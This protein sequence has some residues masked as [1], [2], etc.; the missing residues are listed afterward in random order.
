[1]VKKQFLSDN[2]DCLHLLSLMFYMHNTLPYYLTRCVDLLPAFVCGLYVT[3]LILID[4]NCPQGEKGDPGANG[5]D[6]E[7]GRPVSTICSSC[8]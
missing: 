3:Q 2:S 7:P 6:G 5:D 1:M 8:Y 4:N